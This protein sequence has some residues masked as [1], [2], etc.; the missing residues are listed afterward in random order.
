MPRKSWLWCIVLPCFSSTCSLLL[1]NSAGSLFR[2]PEGHTVCAW[3]LLTEGASVSSATHSKWF[4]SA[5]IQNRYHWERQ[6]TYWGGQPCSQP[7]PT[8]G[9]LFSGCGISGLE[10]P[11]GFW[12][13]LRKFIPKLTSPC[14]ESGW[15]LSTTYKSSFVH[16]EMWAHHL[17][18]LD[19]QLN[20]YV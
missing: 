4:C 14:P 16:R 1:L 15:T 8:L 13:W 11:C 17:S 2:F 9:W 18:Q 5:K 7:S 10:K 19:H 20:F 3:F 12:C 6:N